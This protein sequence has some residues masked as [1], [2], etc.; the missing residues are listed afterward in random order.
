MRRLIIILSAFVFAS[1]LVSFAALSVDAQTSSQQYATEDTAQESTTPESTTLE[2]TT[3]EPTS[4]PSA[5]EVSGGAVSEG[6]PSG[7]HASAEE[8]ARMEPA[9]PY[10][11][12]VDNASPER[13]SAQGWERSSEGTL[14]YG[15]D[16]DQP[17]EGAG[18]AQFKVEIPATDY[19]TVYAWWPVREGNSAEARFGVSTVS[20]V[21]WT[22]VNQ[23]RDGGMWIRLGE[24]EMQAGDGYAV[25]ISPDSA[26][27]G[28]VVADA[29]TVVRGTQ[30]AP[31]DDAASD[32]MLTARGGRHNGRDVVR[33]ARRH[34]GTEYVRSP[35]G[36]C[37]A[38]RAEDCSCHT[39]MVFRKFDRR[40]PDDPIKQAKY[41][42]R[43]RR[44]GDL[45]PGDL[46]FFKEGGRVITHVAIYA[47]GGDIV[48]AS[49]Y[50]D[51]V[52]ERPMKYVDGFVFGQRLPPR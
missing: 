22:E 10:S 40:L 25:Q 1:V 46:V 5:P 30:V 16:Y 41:G 23:K 11:Q 26:D 47:G 13:F 39:K 50:W 20:G 6:S 7:A 17:S 38:F 31:P 2:S 27:N 37:D 45:R 14:Y 43:I 3:Q 4:E 9:E 32:S 52:V 48:H 15:G 49:S 44:K 8:L 33:A 21:E 12:V 35:P 51:K 24:Y 34:I 36:P 18:P 42:H 29:V 28:R 19:Y